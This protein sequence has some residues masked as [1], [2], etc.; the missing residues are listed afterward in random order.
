[1]NNIIIKKMEEDETLNILNN[2]NDCI[3]CLSNDEPLILMINNFCDCFENVLICE[4][5]FIKWLFKN[6]KCFVCRKVFINS[7]G[8]R[9]GVYDIQIK[10]IHVKILIKIEEMY[11]NIPNKRSYN[12]IKFIFNYIANS[13]TL[14]FFMGVYIWVTL[15]FTIQFLF[16]NN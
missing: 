11:I 1:M 16:F 13:N 9:F 6:N 8:N 15:N 3:I 4:K 5:C 7:D 2:N 14:I 10:E 12:L